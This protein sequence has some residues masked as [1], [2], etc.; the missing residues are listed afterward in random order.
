[1]PHRTRDGGRAA[2]LRRL[3]LLD[4]T[5][6]ARRV[7]RLAPEALH[8]LIRRAGLEDC[9]DLLEAASDPQLAALLD[10]DLWAAP[11]AGSDER[12]DA[13]RFGDWVEGLVERDAAAAAR[14]VARLDPALVVTGL[15]RYVRVVDPGVLEPTA[16][17]DDEPSEHRPFAPPDLTAEIGGYLV[18]ARRSEAWDAVVSLLL[19]LSAERGDCFHAL[20]RGC[21]RLSNAG[22][23]EDGL[24]HLLDSPDQWLHDVAVERAD[25]RAER[26]FVAPAEARA[27]LARARPPVPPARAAGPLGIATKA[28]RPAPARALRDARYPDPNQALGLQSLIEYLR[29][30]HPDLRFTREREL[31]FLANTLVAGCGL[32]SGSFTPEQ[33]AEAVLATCSLGL[34]RQPMAPGVDYLVGHGLVAIFE[35][36][37]AALHREVSLFVAAGLLAILRDVA[38]GRSETIEDLQALRRSLEGQLSAGTPWLAR[39]EL[40]VLQALDLPAW[41][42]LLGLLSE[43]P[44]IPEA[45]SAIVERRAGRIDPHG[46]AF[47]A[48]AADLF[49]VRGFMLTL[50]RL[51]AG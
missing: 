42:G 22:H 39:E 27:F 4:R 13:D 20:M 43:C 24:D 29:D 5:G 18:H 11:E 40:E 30:E 21:R 14:L 47:I 38:G 31:A 12:F 10:L 9:V 36:G 7:P 17:S 45:V 34:L 41:Y 19:E 6:L 23:E 51:L 3:R 46:F 28:L 37:W 26:G 25:R 1:M 33:A 2:E 15:S 35:D 44:V 32:G 48:T 8:R 49:T 50:P 16:S